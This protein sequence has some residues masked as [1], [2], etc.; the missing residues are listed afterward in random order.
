MNEVIYK[1]HTQPDQHTFQ[2]DGLPDTALGQRIDAERQALNQIKVKP[3]KLSSNRSASPNHIVIMTPP[4]K[5]LQSYQT[6]VAVTT[7]VN[8]EIQI[9]Q[10]DLDVQYWNFSK[11][12]SRYLHEFLELGRSDLQLRIR[13]GL[14]NFKRLNGKRHRVE[15]D[16]SI[17]YYT[18]EQKQMPR[19]GFKYVR[20]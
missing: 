15:K 12:T 4:W 6:I 11:T 2:R 7:R 10:I 8:Y 16:G 13:N 5:A 19:G 20:A 18:E 3:L 1:L 9:P 17:L 14:I